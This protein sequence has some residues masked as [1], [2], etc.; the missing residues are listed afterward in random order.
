MI[1]KRL[2][3]FESKDIETICIELTVSKKKWCV[4]F[5]CRP[6][7]QDKNTFFLQI[8]KNLN[9]IVNEYENIIVAGDLNIDLSN[10]KDF[11][12]NHISDLRDT[13]ARTNLVKSKTCFK[14]VD[15]TLIDVIL[16]NKPN[17]FQKTSVF[18]TGLSD[19]H[20][21]VVTIFRS[22]FIKLPPKII[23]YR[24]YKTFNQKNFIYELDQKLI[25]G[26]IYRTENSYSKLTEILS[27]T[28]NKHAPMKSKTVR[29]N[30]APFMNKEL[31]KSIM[32]KSRI[33]NKYLKWP[34]R[35]NYLEYKKIKNKCNNLLKKSKK[36]YFQK[37]TGEGSASS[38]HSG[39]QSNLSLV[40]KEFYQT[41]TL[42]LKP[43]TIAK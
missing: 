41:I 27:E 39:T 40:A 15:G 14:T 23:R 6:P 36:I 21:L 20:K 33:K 37:L 17:C 5:A 7:K 4:F 19:F 31:S 38:K 34:S 22:T 35:E 26:D 12:E 11:S 18:E 28:L 16:T 13:F 24:S 32:N 42:S 3:K 43:K 30:H 10:S 9:L 25:Q 2:K 8:S 29:G 1:S